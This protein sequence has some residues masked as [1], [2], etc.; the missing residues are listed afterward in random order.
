MEAS[1]AFPRQMTIDAVKRK[2]CFHCGTPP[3]AQVR[4]LRS[5]PAGMLPKRL[6]IYKSR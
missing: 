1:P 3:S 5:R 6:G 2:L 4:C